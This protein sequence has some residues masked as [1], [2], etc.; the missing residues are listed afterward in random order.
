MVTIMGTTL[1]GERLREQITRFMGALA[2]PESTPAG[3]PSARRADGVLEF[4]KHWRVRGTEPADGLYA[5]YSD[6]DDVIEFGLTERSGSEAR[7]IL[8]AS[9]V[10]TDDGGELNVVS[11]ANTEL[12]LDAVLTPQS[13]QPLQDALRFFGEVL[14]GGSA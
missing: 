12:N 9:L 7:N 3:T 5:T 4:Y 10:L 11:E 8:Q 2:V 14:R 6:N 13:T 1:A